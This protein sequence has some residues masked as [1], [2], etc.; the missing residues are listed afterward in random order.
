MILVRPAPSDKLL[1]DRD[2]APSNAPSCGPGAAPAFRTDAASRR[3]T[4]SA[5]PIRFAIGPEIAQQIRH[6]RRT[7]HLRRSQRQSAHRAQLLLELA[8]DAGVDGQ[9]PRVVRTRRQLIDQQRLR[10]ASRKT[11]RT[12][13]PPRPALQARSAP[14]LPLPW[15]PSPERARVQSTHPE[16]AG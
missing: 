14:A 11:R 9:V 1:P 7:V 6:R 15:R 4:R 12:A 16:Y 13:R 3:E 5:R 10:R 2:S 8:G